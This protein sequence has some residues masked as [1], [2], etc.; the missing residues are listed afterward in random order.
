M[1][2]K[3]NEKEEPEEEE[4]DKN[5]LLMSEAGSFSPSKTG[6]GK[7]EALFLKQL[8]VFDSMLENSGLQGSNFT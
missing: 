1:R 7:S 4:K 3:K 6:S 2:K 5:S 8:E